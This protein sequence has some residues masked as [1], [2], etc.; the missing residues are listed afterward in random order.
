M[1]RIHKRFDEIRF[2]GYFGLIVV[3]IVFYIIFWGKL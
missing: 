2:Y 1:K 3:V